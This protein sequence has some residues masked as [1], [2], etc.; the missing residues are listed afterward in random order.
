MDNEHQLEDDSL[1]D[2]EPVYLFHN[3]GDRTGFSKQ[4]H[5]AGSS[6]LEALKI[7]NLFVRKTVVKSVALVK[8]RSDRCMNDLN[9]PGGNVYLHCF[10]IRCFVYV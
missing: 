10:V 5:I 8:M 4:C 9:H 7:R 1:R 2:R 6:I 3:G